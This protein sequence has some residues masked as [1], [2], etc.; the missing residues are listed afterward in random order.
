MSVKIVPTAQK[1]ANPFPRGD[2]QPILFR[3][4]KIEKRSGKKHTIVC[5]FPLQLLS[6]LTLAT[7]RRVTLQGNE[8]NQ[9]HQFA[10]HGERGTSAAPGRFQKEINLIL[11]TQ[12]HFL[13]SPHDKI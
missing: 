7:L 1:Q 12:T 10:A 5:F 9:K 11:K 6:S 13:M 8:I 4:V 3:E 2:R